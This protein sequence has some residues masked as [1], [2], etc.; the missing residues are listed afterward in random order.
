MSHA[1]A[2]SGGGETSGV[3]STSTPRASLVTHASIK[4]ITKSL[5][6]SDGMGKSGGVRQV[7]IDQIRACRSHYG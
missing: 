1:D 6:Y 4:S 5:H 2:F 7:P 3:L